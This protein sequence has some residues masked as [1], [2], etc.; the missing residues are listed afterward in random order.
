MAAVTF[1]LRSR[2]DLLDVGDYIAN[3]SRAAARRLVGKLLEQCK[4]IG[5]APLG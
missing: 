2:Q 3:D 4:R 5:N 1:S